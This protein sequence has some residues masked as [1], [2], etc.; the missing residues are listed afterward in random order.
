MVKYCEHCGKEVN[1]EDNV[2]LS[3]G[4]SM[5]KTP[6]EKPIIQ[7]KINEKKIAIF[8]IVFGILGIYPLLGIGGIVGMSLAKKGLKDTKKRY[9]KHLKTGFWISFSSFV[10]WTLALI[11]TLIIELIPVFED[12]WEIF[13]DFIRLFS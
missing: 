7:P 6:Y 10:F 11:T 5:D 9:R 4:S 13:M 1:Q 2:C 12:F 8:S 3:C